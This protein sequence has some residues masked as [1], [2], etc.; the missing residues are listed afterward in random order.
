MTA[1]RLPCDCGGE[2]RRK[3]IAMVIVPSSIGVFGPLSL[4]FLAL[5]EGRSWRYRE[6]SN[7]VIRLYIRNGLHSR[8][9]GYPKTRQLAKRESSS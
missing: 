4:V 6:H 7:T 1:P 2:P 5:G 8:L 9:R 3:A